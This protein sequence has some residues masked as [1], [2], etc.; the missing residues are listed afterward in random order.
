MA[1]AKISV[2]ALL[3]TFGFIGLAVLGEGGLA[4]LFGKPALVCLVVVTIALAVAS[5]FTSGNLD[6]GNEEDRS[7]RWVLGA[8]TILGVVSGWLPA[9]TDRRELWTIDGDTLRWI[10]VLLFAGGGGLRLWPVFVLGNRFSGLV[11]IQRDHRLVT[12]GI[13]AIVR[14]PS[15]LGMLISLLGWGLAF[16]SVAGIALA[17]LTIVP[18]IARIDAEEAL[19]SKTFGADYDDYR[20]RTARLLPGIY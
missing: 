16:R 11:A 13:Y 8:F 10:G 19:L 20:R 15:Y 12:T 14:H 9:Y 6:A 5:L 7:N 18:V 4:G 2:V 3:T 1:S 17:A